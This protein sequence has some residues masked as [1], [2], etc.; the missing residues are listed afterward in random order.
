MSYVIPMSLLDL[1]ALYHR[2][3]PI[4]YKPIEVWGMMITVRDEL[5]YRLN[6][7]LLPDCE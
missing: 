3:G 4:E 7:E 1:L 5:V 6:Y 2:I